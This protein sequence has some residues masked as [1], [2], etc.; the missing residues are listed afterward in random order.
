MSKLTYMYDLKYELCIWNSVVLFVV[1]CLVKY[2]S[3]LIQIRLQSSVVLLVKKCA[4]FLAVSLRA[5][6][7]AF[8]S[9]RKSSVFSVVICIVKYAPT[10]FKNRA[11][12]VL[13]E[14]TAHD[15]VRRMSA[16]KHICIWFNFGSLSWH[17]LLL[18]VSA[19]LYY[20]HPHHLQRV[21]RTRHS[22]LALLGRICDINAITADTTIS[23][24][25]AWSH[26]WHQC[27]HR[28]RGSL[29]LLCLVAFV[30]SMQSPQSK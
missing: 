1:I 8:L 17:P 14:V 2:A 22:H 10:Q 25:F 19:C 9:I 24:Y 4:D 30:I 29:V 20:W 12:P 27:D 15:F 21:W 6:M 23:S 5:H 13:L 28:R 26:S 18:S 3:A 7:W 11:I 16:R